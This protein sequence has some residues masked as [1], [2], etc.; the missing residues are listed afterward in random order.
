MEIALLRNVEGPD[1]S[2]VTKLLQDTNGILVGRRHDNPMLDTI[3]YE[4]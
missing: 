4:F 3:V 2:T 1:F